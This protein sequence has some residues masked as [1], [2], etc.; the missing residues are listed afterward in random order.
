MLVIDEK[1]I[2]GLFEIRAH[3]RGVSETIG[4]LDLF[5]AKSLRFSAKVLVWRLARLIGVLLKVVYTF[6][7]FFVLQISSLANMSNIFEVSMLILSPLESSL[8]P[9]KFV[10]VPVSR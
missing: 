9:S 3:L 10:M 2:V 7:D 6:L 8:F 5:A 4:H 1:S